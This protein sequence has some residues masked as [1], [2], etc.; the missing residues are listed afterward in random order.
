MAKKNQTRDER[1]WRNRKSGKL[2]KITEVIPRLRMVTFEYVKSGI[3]RILYI[4]S[5]NKKF[6]M[7]GDF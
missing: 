7:M 4:N 6:E 5:F 2:V 3:S 1:L